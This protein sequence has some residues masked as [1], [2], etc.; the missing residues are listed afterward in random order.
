MKVIALF[1]NP[2]E[3]FSNIFLNFM[4]SLWMVLN[5]F[6]LS[7]YFF[8]IF[9]LFL[10]MGLADKSPTQFI[11]VILPNSS[12]KSILIDEIPWDWLVLLSNYEHLVRLVQFLPV[13]LSLLSTSVYIWVFF[14][15]GQK[16][17]NLNSFLN[18][19]SWVSKSFARSDCVI[20]K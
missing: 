7:L 20:L 16:W 13:G 6:C 12:F 14:K 8:F 5:S 19:G 3:L 11:C 17:S 2:T 1:W 4:F 15:I 10:P 18:F 9:T